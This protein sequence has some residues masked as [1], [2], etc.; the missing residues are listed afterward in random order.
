MMP[1]YWHRHGPA[2]ELDHAGA[3]GDMR[4][5]EWG[6][7]QGVGIAHDLREDQPCVTDPLGRRALKSR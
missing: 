4:R 2:A 6:M 7:L 5:L 3:A 1:E